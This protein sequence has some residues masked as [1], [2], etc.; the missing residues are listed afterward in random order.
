MICA[1]SSSFIAFARGEPQPDVATVA[2]ALTHRLLVLAPASV[3]EL[4]SDP[5]LS[6]TFQAL[7][8]GIPCLEISSG[9][10][11]RA[12]KLRSLLIGRH[13]RPKIA[14]T[15]IAQ[16]CL[17]HDVPLVTRDQDFKAFRQYAGLKLL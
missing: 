11:E 5:K 9:Y 16:S 8:A 3:T 14:D 13:F 17:D 1:D 2:E 10:W 4:L 6:S 15:L 7:I 12:G